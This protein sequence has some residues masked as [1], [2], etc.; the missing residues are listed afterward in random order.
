[1][2]GTNQVI[3]GL[4]V[5]LGLLATVGSYYVAFQSVYIENTIIRNHQLGVVVMALG[6]IRS[7]FEKKQDV[8]I[9]LHGFPVPRVCSETKTCVRVRAR[10]CVCVHV[11]AS[12]LIFTE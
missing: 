4:I 2:W 7:H 12:L 6:C 8:L 11:V 10:V 5:V 1:M 9:D 3:R